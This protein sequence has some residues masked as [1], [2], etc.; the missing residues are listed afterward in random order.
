MS[1]HGANDGS[2]RLIAD[3]DDLIARAQT[4][5]DAARRS[6]AASITASEKLSE[7]L[8]RRQHTGPEALAT[9]VDQQDDAAFEASRS[10]VRDATRRFLGKED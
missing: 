8:D 3:T 9:D 1:D 5:R 4:L 2:D 10:R 7:T 6:L